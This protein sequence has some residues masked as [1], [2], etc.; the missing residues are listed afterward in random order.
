MEDM[1]V[2][3]TGYDFRPAHAAMQRYVDGNVLAGKSYPVAVTFMSSMIGPSVSPPSRANG[4]SRPAL[5]R[6]GFQTRP[7]QTGPTH[8]ILNSVNSPCGR[9][10]LQEFCSQHSLARLVPGLPR[11]TRRMEPLRSAIPP[12]PP[13]HIRAEPQSRRCRGVSN[14][15][16]RSRGGSRPDECLHEPGIARKV[17]P[18]VSELPVGDQ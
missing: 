13:C 5:C 11:V 12:Q 15:P 2:T 17:A 10:S 3:A 6:G 7:H 18:P 8:H 14:P 16:Q 1:N 9:S 4:G